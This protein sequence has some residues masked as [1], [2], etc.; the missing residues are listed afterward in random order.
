MSRCTGDAPGS[1][2][3]REKERMKTKAFTAALILFFSELLIALIPSFPGHRLESQAEQAA[4]RF[5]KTISESKNEE[6]PSFT[7]SKDGDF[8]SPE[9]FR[10]AQEYNEELYRNR[11]TGFISISAY[12]EPSLCLSDYGIDDGVFGTVCIPKLGV[13]LP[14]YLGASEENMAKGAAHLSQTSLPIGGE[15]TNCVLAG[16]CGFNGADYFRYLSTLTEDDEVILTTLWSEDHYR[17]SG[18]AVIA[19]DDI[20]SVMI[21]PGREL[22]TLLTCHP[23]ASGGKYR[24]LAICEKEIAEVDP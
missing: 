8:P 12:Q 10:A 22:L 5:N 9:L 18:V 20:A 3:K 13:T 19:P 24:F 11:Q 2:E 6:S 7:E 16:H 15:N 1:L 23:Y 4:E 14:I 17:V 21:Q